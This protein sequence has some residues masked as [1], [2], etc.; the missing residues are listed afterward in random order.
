MAAMAAQLMDAEQLD[1]EHESE[2]IWLAVEGFPHRYSLRFILLT[3]RRG[4]G[5]WP[6]AVVPELLAAVGE[7]KLSR[8]NQQR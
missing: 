5:A 4:E 2:T 3:G 6:A 7:L 8:E 1:C